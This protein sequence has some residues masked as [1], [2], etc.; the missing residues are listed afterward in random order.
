VSDSFFSFSPSLSSLHPS[1]CS[2]TFL[3]K[4]LFAGRTPLCPFF[5]FCGPVPGTRMLAHLLTFPWLLPLPYNLPKVIDIGFSAPPTLRV[6][7]YPLLAYWHF[8]V[9][10][11]FPPP[12]FGTGYHL[13][14]K[15]LKG[16]GTLPSP[17][18]GSGLS[19]KMLFPRHPSMWHYW[20]RTI[21]SLPPTLPIQNLFPPSFSPLAP[22]CC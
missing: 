12:C 15:T 19:P 20:A 4:G 3:P 2:K 21:R 7:G 22:C 14:P 8:T 1:P 5:I 18:E 13:F 17:S 16:T 6:T 9:T 10:S 11:F